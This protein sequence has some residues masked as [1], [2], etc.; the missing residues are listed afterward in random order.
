M[1]H[2]E[3][4]LAAIRGEIPDRMP[5]V[6]RLDFWFRAHTYQGTM[7]PHLRGLSILELADRLGVAAYAIIPDFTDCPTGTEMLDRALGIYQVPV[8]PY[9]VSMENV[10]RRVLKQ[11]R[12]T[13]VEYHTPLGT[14]RTTT[15]FTEEM[16]AAGASVGYITEHAV[17][18]LDDFRI[19]G[20]IFSHLKVE[21]RM[22]GY[23]ACR[24]QVGDRSLV[25]GYASPAASPVHH[26]MKEFMPV[27][28]FFYAMHD[29][30]AELERLTEEMKPYYQ[31]ILEI[32]AD[33]PAEV[34]MLGANY[35]DAIT[36]PPFFARHILPY[37]RDYADVL[38]RRG[39][40]LMTHTDGENRKLLKL[41]LEAGFDV[42]DSVCPYPMTSCRLE[43]IREAF[44]DRITIV[45]GIPSV[46]LCPGSAS[47]DDCRQFI[48]DLLARYRGESHF[49][50]G[51][52][53]M[54]TAD[55]EWSRLEYITERVA[56]TVWS[57]N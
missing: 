34:I 43:E 38:H 42:A 33:S 55:A 56:E 41:Y 18:G 13:I 22:E 11:G 30:P 23:L 5:W 6:P 45:G 28:Q 20:Y 54:V 27:D 15:V 19:L 17:R 7:P 46:L 1:T 10:E 8:I 53:D 32:S 39:K 21:P 49:I 36:Y 4:M 26:V 47:F 14:I 25:V 57:K 35:D 3:R 50:L 44:R 31:R 2:R 48:D 9:R 52:S 29:Y 37:L 16:L 24:E 12:E 40:Y 51:V